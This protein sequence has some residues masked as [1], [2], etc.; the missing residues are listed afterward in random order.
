MTTAMPQGPR[1]SD[2][3]EFTSESD[4]ETEAGRTDPA[5]EASVIGAVW[6]DQLRN[7]LLGALDLVRRALDRNHA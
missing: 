4:A 3:P 5:S 2:L 1:A 6:R 7:E